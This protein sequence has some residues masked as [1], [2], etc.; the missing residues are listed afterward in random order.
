MNE[1]RRICMEIYMEIKKENEKY[2]KKP[3]FKKIK[4][5]N[6]RKKNMNKIVRRKKNRRGI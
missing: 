2:K 5:K 4:E 6:K 1:K 3:N